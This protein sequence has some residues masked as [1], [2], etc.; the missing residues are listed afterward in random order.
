MPALRFDV[1]IPNYRCFSSEGPVHFAMRPG[2]TSLVGPN[3]AGKS[4]LLR[5]FYELRGVIGHV[6]SAGSSQGYRRGTHV[7]VAINGVGD[8]L[9][10]CHNMNDQDASVQI[11]LP[12]TADNVLSGM[13]LRMSRRTPGSWQID[14]RIGPG[15]Q[16]FE[17]VS[18]PSPPRVGA[19]AP[20]ALDTS[21]LD[22]FLAEFA[23]IF[24]LPATRV[25][26]GEAQGDIYD[27]KI[28]NAF[29]HMWD[30]W[31][32]G[33]NRG[34]N[35][36]AQ[37][38]T[39]DIGKLFGFRHLEISAT[40]D[41]RDLHVAIDRRPYKLRELGAGLAQFVI[42]L[43]STA[44]QEPVWLLI[45]E[46]EISLHSSLQLD[47]LTTLASYATGGVVFA[48]HSLGLARAAD[49]VFSL[50]HNNGHSVLTPFE[51]TGSDRKSV[52]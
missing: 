30:Q 10:I 47:F 9:E 29:I 24:Y 7:G 23:K 51:T 52:V 12:V 13:D 48:T 11:R 27:L 32:T 38:V 2:L 25:A 26:I 46:P 42:V 36:A 41:K 1:T 43:A 31:K 15:H 19:Q 35:A 6:K 17:G 14:F 3:N 44:V 50:R 33:P 34:Q 5:L 20:V 8:P 37:R 21:I 40:P 22:Q 16:L 39:D 4:S 18:P 28:G 45:D 49:R